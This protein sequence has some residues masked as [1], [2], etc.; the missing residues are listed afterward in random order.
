MKKV[1]LLLSILGQTLAYSQNLEGMEGLFFIPSAEINQDAKVSFGVNYLDKNLIS[2]GGYKNNATNYFLSFNFL[3]FIETSLR[4][5]RLNGLPSTNN[6]AIGD[7]TAS[8]K[9]RL[10]EESHIQPTISL[11]LHDLFTVFG[12]QSAVHNNSF[13]LIA[14]KNF[15]FDMFLSNIAIT[16]GY[17]TDLMS[18]ANH[19][20]VGGFQWDFLETI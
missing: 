15:E 8:I 9:I 20:F 11:G 10:L 4:V 13:Y 16:I 6:Q 2:F 14:T 1:I 3:P 17:G 12:G 5:T 18:A 7:R 19:N